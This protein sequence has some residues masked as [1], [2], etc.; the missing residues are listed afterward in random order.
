VSDSNDEDA[1]GQALRTWV[2]GATGL[3]EEAV[4]FQ[5]Q[6]GP[7]PAPA[8][9]PGAAGAVTIGLGDFEPLGLEWREDTEDTVAK[10][11]TAQAV[12]THRVHVTVK[13]FTRSTIGNA[14]ARALLKKAVLAL[15]LDTVLTA[16]NAAGLGCLNVSAVQSADAVKGAKWESQAVFEVFFC[17][18]Q[19]AT[20]T[21]PYIAHVNG[22]GTV[23]SPGGAD[24]V[25]PIKVDLP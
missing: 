6:D 9:V 2:L 17:V 16:L 21:I 22:E 4:I 25:V 14:A 1:L 12:G 11:V 18:L 19:T 8:E 3:P 5:R 15:G 10:T 7:S 24:L 23:H 13:G 20:E